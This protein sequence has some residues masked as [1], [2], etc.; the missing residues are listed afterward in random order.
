MIFML[1]PLVAIDTNID[2][3]TESPGM[4][5]LLEVRKIIILSILA[6]VV[7]LIAIGLCTV[8]CKAVQRKRR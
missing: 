1:M 8:M 5:Q 7:I 6:A 4:Y 2:V 3:A